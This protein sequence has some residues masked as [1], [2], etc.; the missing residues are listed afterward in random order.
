MARYTDPVCRLCRRA[1]VKLFLKGERCFTPRCAVERRRKPPGA[2]PLRRRRTSDWGMQLREKQ[3]A[4]Q[5]Y[6]VLER[7]FHRYY[8]EALGRTGITGQYMLQL[9][10]RRLDNLVYRMNFA[11][12][13]S[14]ARQLV[15]HGH[16]TV[17]G[18][19]VDIPSYQVKVDDVV[20]WKETS[21]KTGIYALVAGEIPK[22]PLPNWISLDAENMTGQVLSLPEPSDIDTGVDMRLVIEHYA[23]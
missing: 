16:I 8:V 22:R 1:G 4:R 21:K 13:R 6:G 11:D 12:S 18:R 20:A 15:S 19:K 17:N 5:I 23:R 2:Q 14:Q 10:E 9:L 3:K 7:Q